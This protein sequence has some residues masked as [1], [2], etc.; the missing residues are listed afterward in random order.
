MSSLHLSLSSNGLIRVNLFVVW[1][2]LCCEVKRD[3][4]LIICSARIIYV[5]SVMMPHTSMVICPSKVPKMLSGIF[6]LES[7]L[8]NVI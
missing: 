1:M 7:S 5:Y 3:C 4:V 6:L 2:W 8:F